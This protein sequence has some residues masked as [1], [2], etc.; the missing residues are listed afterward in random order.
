MKDPLDSQT[1]DLVHVAA[2]PLSGAARQKRRRDKLRDLKEREG[3]KPVML[4]A[5]ERDLLRLA[6]DLYNDFR[7][8]DSY[9]QQM[10]DGM[11]QKLVPGADSGR[12]VPA[13]LTSCARKPPKPVRFGSG[14]IRMQRASRPAGLS[15]PMKPSAR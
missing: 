4:T 15:A 7:R 8:P 13:T 6:L 5:L 14:C 9:E 1:L 2:Q 10:H 3:L 11:L 12:K